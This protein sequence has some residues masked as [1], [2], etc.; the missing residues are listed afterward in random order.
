LPRCSLVVLFGLVLPRCQAHSHP[1]KRK[2]P[3]RVAES[4]PAQSG[5]HPP[6][7][8]L[9]F[10]IGCAA[11][12]II[13]STGLAGGRCFSPGNGDRFPSGRVVIKTRT[14]RI[15]KRHTGFAFAM[16]LVVFLFLIAFSPRTEAPRGNYNWIECEPAGFSDSCQSFYV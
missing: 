15:A 9:G 11:V 3:D 14:A 16:P 6:A 13:R 8:G 12:G 1:T 2:F 10:V 7:P 4:R 5:T